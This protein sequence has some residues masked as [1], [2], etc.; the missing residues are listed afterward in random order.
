MSLPAS[1]AAHS[2]VVT[3][4]RDGNGAQDVLAREV[5]GD[6]VLRVLAPSG[7]A[8]RSATRH[9]RGPCEHCDTVNISVRMVQN[10]T[11]VW[12]FLLH[13]VA[14]LGLVHIHLELAGPHR[15]ILLPVH[16]KPHPASSLIITTLMST[17]T[18]Q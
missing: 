13:E 8:A 7:P 10:S 11:H 18:M 2:A 16:L 1:A 6:G 3:E 14:R 4:A 5:D 15:L 12:E 9:C 17:T